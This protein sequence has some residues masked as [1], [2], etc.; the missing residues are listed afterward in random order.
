MDGD[1]LAQVVFLLVYPPAF[2]V[3]IVVITLVAAVAAQRGSGR[4]DPAWSATTGRPWAW[5]AWLTVLVHV[6]V[7]A[8]LWGSRNASYVPVL[9]FW[10]G[11][12]LAWL[13]VSLVRDRARR[14]GPPSRERQHP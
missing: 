3:G 10:T 9:L 14:A 12:P 2:P 8:V 5:V 11:L 13:V 6:V 1:G 7:H 4:P